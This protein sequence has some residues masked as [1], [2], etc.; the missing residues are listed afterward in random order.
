MPDVP[1]KIDYEVE[2]NATSNLK[3]IRK[4]WE[5]N[6]KSVDDVSKSTDGAAESSDK[7]NE[8]SKGLMSSL[9]K[10]DVVAA[11][12]AAGLTAFA[13]QGVQAFEETES[14]SKR[15]EFRL[16]SLGQTQGDLNRLNAELESNFDRLGFSVENQEQVMTRLA[17]KTSDVEES[18][19]LLQDAMDTSVATGEDFVDVSKD[20]AE[21]ATGDI[22]ALEELGILTE[23]Q[24]DRLREIDDAGR[25]ASEAL[26]LLRQ[27]VGGAS[28]EIDPQVRMIRQM[29][30]GYRELNAEAGEFVLKAGEMAL[31]MATLNTLGSENATATSE[32][33]TGLEKVN[34]GLG[35][36]ITYLD[37]LDNSKSVDEQSDSVMKLQAGFYELIGAEEEATELTRKRLGYTEE[38][39]RAQRELAEAQRKHGRT[40]EEAIAIARRYNQTLRETNE[41]SRDQQRINSGFSGQSFPQLE[42][43]NPVVTS[44]GT[45]GGEE[46]EQQEEEFASRAELE[47]RKANIAYEAQKAHEERLAELRQ[48]RRDREFERDQEARE[49]R[50]AREVE[51]IEAEHAA[52]LKKHEERKRRLEAAVEERRKALR[53]GFQGAAGGLSEAGAMVSGFDAELS[54]VDAL[55]DAERE[56]LDTMHAQNDALRQNLEHMSSIASEGGNIAMSIDAVFQK[57]WDFKE[58]ASE[59]V[60][61]FD[62]LSSVAGA[63]AGV[64]I[65][66]AKKLAKVKAGV[67]FAAAAGALGFGFATGQPQYFA[68]AAKHTSSGIGYSAVAGQGKGSSDTGGI[69]A[70]GGARGASAGVDRPEAVDL[71]A[72]KEANKQAFAEALRENQNEGRTVQ[73]IVNQQGAILLER[74]PTTA[75]KTRR[76]LDAAERNTLRLGA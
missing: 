16:Q 75:R 60:S 49:Q 63:V 36:A 51:A 44:G 42:G 34:K 45:G 2:D 69:G 47:R 65:E 31:R 4:E 43:G 71:G 20:I 28:E 74:D 59:T 3:S 64:G 50:V 66:D 24:T 18:T 70:G 73:Y 8:S 23:A 27:K 6:K 38:Q 1:A 39:T 13:V 68:A 17:T 5:K 37:E 76:T 15:Y 32:M 56:R 53:S 52:W 7:M 62:S 58:A 19:R 54:R 22:N 12:A 46:P 21:A 72:V 26:E 29:K 11:G 48:E 10:L 14:A 30:A 67:H 57:Q 41:L 33:A 9:D 40:S 55:N 61:A 35:A 25:R